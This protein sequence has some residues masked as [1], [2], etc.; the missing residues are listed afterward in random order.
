MPQSLTSTAMIPDPPDLSMEDI[1][2]LPNHHFSQ[3]PQLPSFTMPTFDVRFLT[4]EMP[5]VSRSEA[6]AF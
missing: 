3:H 6:G 4:S 2:D 5:Y 1:V